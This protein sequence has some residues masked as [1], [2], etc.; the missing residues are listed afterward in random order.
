MIIKKDTPNYP[1]AHGPVDYV[2][3]LSVEGGYKTL[4]PSRRMELR[5]NV[6]DVKIGEGIEKSE[7]VGMPDEWELYGY[8]QLRHATDHRR[9]FQL[10]PCSPFG[11]TNTIMKDVTV[12]VWERIN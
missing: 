10:F 5:H 7:A 1:T 2:F 6:E 3:T 9:T 4:V 11:P 12:F 8:W